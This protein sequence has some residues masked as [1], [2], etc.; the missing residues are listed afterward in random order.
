MADLSYDVN[1]N[2]T[3][4][5][6][7][8]AELQTR[9][10]KVNNAFGGLR[11][12]IAGLAIGAMINNV[13]RMADSIQDLNDATGIA[14]QNLLGF[15]QAVLLNGGS[16]ELASTSVLKLVDS[17]GKAAE[18][19]KETQSAFQ[20]VGV[21][22][23]DLRTLSEQDILRKTV[24]GLAKI[25][26]VGKRVILATELLGKGFRGVNIQGV[27]SQLDSA[28]AASIKHAEAVRQTAEMQNK[29]DVTFQKLQLSILKAIQPLVDFINKL[30][31]DTINRSIDAI[32]KLGSAIAALAASFY[33]L[34]KIAKGFVLIASSI[35]TAYA[36]FKIGVAIFAGGFASIA[37]TSE[38]AFGYVSRFFRATAMF[39]KA[40]GPVK[41]ML[42]L[43]EKLAIRIPY[44]GRAL[45]VMTVGLVRMIP[46]VGML[47]AGLI[48]LNETL[49]ALTGTNLAGWF[50]KAAESLEKFVTEK[51]PK[52]AAAINAINEKLGMGP[53]PSVA[54]A[55]KA[56]H[57]NEM[58]RI[59]ARA[60]AIAEANRI[61]AER[62]KVIDKNAQE[63]AQFGF[64]LK[65]QNEDTY[66]SLQ[67]A[68]DRVLTEANL[69]R[70]QTQGNG[71]NQDEIEILRAQLDA[72][73]ERLNKEIQIRQEIEKLQ[74]QIKTGSK[75]ETL[76]ARIKLLQDQAREVK[77][78][79]DS[80]IQALPEYITKL[81]TA[82]L[83]E[84]DRLRTAENMRVAIEQQ[85]DRQR[86]L[87]DL[88]VQ[89]NDRM[90]ETEFAG[91]QQKRSPLQQQIAA[92][93]EEA[94]K[95]ALEAG[96]VFAASYE[97]MDLTAEQA[98]E[99]ANGLQQIADKYQAIGQAQIDQLN[100]SRSWEAGWK[101]AFDRYMDNA[102][103]AATKAGEVFGSITRNMEN[104][105]DNF[106]DTGKFKFKDF[107]R[108]IIQ[109]MLKIELKAQASKILGMIGGT[110]GIIGA[111]GS[112]FGF[113][114]GGNPPVNKPSI[115]GEKGP[116]LFVP[117]SAGTIVPNNMMQGM[118]N[119]MGSG[120]V[121]APVTN[122]Y[123]TNNINALDARSVAQLFAENRKTLLGTVEMARKEMPYS[124][125]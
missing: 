50:D 67:H 54:A 101:D 125:R 83:L 121:S 111:I 107:A 18:G 32:V 122:N 94:R 2:T 53:A 78:M 88:L 63:I 123:I 8:L 4:A 34:E 105:I 12:A 87:G 56:E 117:K 66:L 72:Q 24:Q 15:Q 46:Y 41:N 77:A 91:A 71:L 75:D 52:L 21:S 106:V 17:I 30:D 61:E 60:D 49:K 31:Q 104:A 57:D 40:N 110:G 36:G 37:K 74:N 13:I 99:L 64:Q 108:S 76:P 68:R 120:M 90:R 118:M 119:A 82:R 51:F 33:V 10:D 44:A 45:L 14:I 97:G 27:A 55:A 38:I 7:N 92:I 124:N 9:V 73:N 43:F 115:V 28:T 98:Q 59:K 19:S 102:T 80:H 39:D 47:I 26:D 93:Q 103:N 20:D 48:V 109:D 23:K 84:E 89:A 113:A 96:R 114:N 81:Q 95:A 69:I 6:R 11:A 85:I 100:Y 16:A 70:L 86:Q 42:T 5:Q 1:I 79:Y 116:E 65:Q 35:A 25:D 112:I 62:R 29:L 22:L 58:A 3:A